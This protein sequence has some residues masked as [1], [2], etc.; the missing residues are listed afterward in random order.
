M[1]AYFFAIPV[2]HIIFA[3]DCLKTAIMKPEEK[4][5]QHPEY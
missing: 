5:E 2:F 3:T 4:S 1:I